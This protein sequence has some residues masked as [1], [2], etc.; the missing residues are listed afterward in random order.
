M[1]SK[2]AN[3]KSLNLPKPERKALPKHWEKK[4]SQ[5]ISDAR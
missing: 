2:S 4:K 3:N 1:N 5:K